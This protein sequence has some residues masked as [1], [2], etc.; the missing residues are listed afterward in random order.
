MTYKS[1][2]R[3]SFTGRLGFDAAARFGLGDVTLVPSLHLFGVY[4]F[5]ARPGP[6][7]AA[8]ALAPT[9][10]MSFELPVN[11]KTWLEYGAGLDAQ[12]GGDAR[13]SVRY[14]ATAGRTDL[15]SGA[16]TGTLS[17]QF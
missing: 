9:A 10:N 11:T 17:V 3:D 4:D 2:S 5:A 7:V 6:L 8:F 13:L 12:I 15:M 16:W 14:D 1:V